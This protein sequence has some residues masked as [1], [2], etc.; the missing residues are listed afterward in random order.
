[1]M[2]TPLKNFYKKVKTAIYLLRLFWQIWKMR[3]TMTAVNH[4]LA[5]SQVAAQLLMMG[6]KDGDDDDKRI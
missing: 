1:M 6:T 3:H 2:L 4:E 5:D